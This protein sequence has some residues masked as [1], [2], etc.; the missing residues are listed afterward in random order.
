MH[1]M[2]PRRA[3]LRVKSDWHAGDR[4]SRRR[5]VWLVILF[6]LALGAAAAIG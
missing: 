6:A 1:G 4:D 2:K 5:V 3:S